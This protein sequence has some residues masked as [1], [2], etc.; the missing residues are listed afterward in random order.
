[1]LTY[2]LLLFSLSF[3]TS[4]PAAPTLQFAK[5]RL[6]ATGWPAPE[7]VAFL[8]DFDGDGS[9]DLGSFITTGTGRV[10]FARNVRGGKFGTGAMGIDFP[11]E[12]KPVSVIEITSIAP[13]R[14]EAG[15]APPATPP[16]AAFHFKQEDGSV[17]IVT[18]NEKD[19]FTISR[20]STADAPTLPYPA[21]RTRVHWRR[22]TGSAIGDFDRDGLPDRLEGA[23]L[24]L[25]TSPSVPVRVPAIETLPPGARFVTGDF[26]GDGRDDILI[27]RNDSTWRLGRDLLL[28]LSY[29]PQ[30]TDYDGDGLDNAREAAL[31]SDPLDAD[32]DFDG[33]LD[34][35]E[36]LGE[37][38][39]DLPAL[40]TSP[41]HKD[42]IVYLQR[43]DQTNGTGVLGEI[44]RAQKTWSE[45]K[46]KNP[47]GA[48]GI[49][50]ITIFLSPL[51]SKDGQRPWWELGAAN[52][53][54]PAQGIA[55][56]MNIA[57]GGGGQSAELGN[58]GCCGEGALYATFLHEFGHQMG[59]THAGGNLTAMCPTYTSLMNYPYSY[60]FNDD[61]N[62]IH[63]S[64]GVL[65]GLVLNETRLTERVNENY[66]KLKFLERGPWR[67]KLKADGTGTWIDWNRNGEFED[68]I[69]RADITDT[70]GV[71]GG[72]R[73]PSGKTVQ[74]PVLISN[75][76]TLAVAGVDR[77]R[78]VF[79]K[80][81]TGEGKWSPE[82]YIQQIKPSGDPAAVATKDCWHLL[83]PTADGVALLSAKTVETLAS[84]TPSTLP[85]SKAC[86]VAVVIYQKRMLALLW[87]GPGQPVRF[88]E[89]MPD[90]TFSVPRDLAGIASVMCPG[91]VENTVTGELCIGGA[92]ATKND[93]A[94][95]RAWILYKLRPAG[96]G[97]EIVKTETVGGAAS[98]WSGNSRT[99]LL[100]ETGRDV[101]PAGRLHFM[102][103][104][105]CDPP[106][107]NGCFWEAITIGNPNESG[108]WRLRRFYDEW[109]TSRSPISAVFH[110]NDIVIAFRWFGN[111]HGDD[112]DNLLISHHGL[113][114]FDQDMRDFDDVTEIAETG[115]SHSIA[116]RLGTVR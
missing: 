52:L 35:W 13:P 53:P 32:T 103:V 85:D 101:G 50:L 5:P 8:A 43:Y 102:G 69:I 61:Y 75:G 41:I 113:G 9:G 83:V 79:V 59:L 73:H 70:Y 15:A 57:A 108:G 110:Q 84:G 106:T 60:G 26:Q 63:Y 91:A 11:P 114:I 80:I 90:G 66:E 39:L 87:R 12:C 22:D 78:R 72:L 42:C 45:L 74:A 29:Q 112:D 65:A 77:E 24:F 2:L 21:G 107:A 49:N 86:D 76:D 64:N 116:W 6:V 44:R 33:L 3:Q 100:F 47:D 7:T 68:G 4:K 25:T 38:G 27:L 88:V 18:S 105:W 23:D 99:T 58:A 89:I 92:T 93:G 109:T 115:L 46:V 30:D 10:E 56:Y 104:G 36:V 19:Q 71:D 40:G 98:G 16:R 54:G 51:P 62:Q 82:T 67:L 97:F 37:G 48:S 55:H 28:I 14:P 81:N 1:M 34:G 94:E 95:K 20:T 96:D 17:F 111:V 31:K